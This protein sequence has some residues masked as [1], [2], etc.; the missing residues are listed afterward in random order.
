MFV[1]A[2]CVLFLSQLFTFPRKAK[3]WD[4]LLRVSRSIQDK[5]EKPRGHL[6]TLTQMSLAKN[7]FRFALYTRELKQ[8]RRRRQQKRHKFAYLTMINSICARFARAFFNFEHFEDV[9]VLSTTWND[10]LCSCV[11]EV[12]I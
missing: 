9:L 4:N 12:S 11:D 8:P 3:F 6:V 10:L 2:V 7:A 1:T 5:Y